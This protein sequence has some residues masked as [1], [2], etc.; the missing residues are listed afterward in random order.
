[1][2]LNLKN[3]AWQLAIFTM[4][5]IAI[6]ATRMLNFCVRNGNRCVHPAITTRLLSRE[7]IL[8]KLN[9]RSLRFLV[10][11]NSWLSPRPISI[12]QLHVSLHFHL[13]PIYL[14][15]FKG[16]YFL[17]NGR[18]HLGVGFALRCFQRLSLPYLAT[19]LCSWQNNRC[20]SGRSTPVLSY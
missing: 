20:T 13:W 16:S 1:M 18:S 8:S 9:N 7:V 5:S 2:K 12:S 14:V 19:R 15:V 4:A 10:V 11:L 6:V 3:E 17:T